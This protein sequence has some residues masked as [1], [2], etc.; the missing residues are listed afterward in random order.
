MEES[1]GKLFIAGVLPGAILSL[2]FVAVVVI[3]CLR[4]PR[5]GPPGTPTSWKA[6]FR[7][8]SGII[9]AV[10]IFLLAIGGLFLGWFS[11]TQAGSIGA[12]SALVMGLVR[13]NLTWKVFFERG[14]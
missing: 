10:I 14:P 7:A 3:L 9:E 13:R 12:G 5:L 8:A 6:K 11:P 2:F 1:I 4:N